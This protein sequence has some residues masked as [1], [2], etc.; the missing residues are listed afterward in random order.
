MRVTTTE[1]GW[2]LEAIGDLEWLFLER[3]PGTASG[4]ELPEEQKRRILP[5]PIVSDDEDGGAAEE[6]EFMEDWNEYVRPELNVAFTEAR[7]QVSDD[8]AT[9]T[10]N[11]SAE[12]MVEVGE[13]PQKNFRLEVD[14]E[15]SENWYSTL[16]QARLLMNEVYDLAESEAELY[17][18]M[19]TEDDD[20]EGEG[21]EGTDD[22][23]DIV[24][25]DSEPD[26]MLWLLLAQYQFY[27]FIQG[28]LL[29]R[30]IKA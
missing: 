19:A 10:R 28:F 18:K 12:A 2:A 6:A 29:E 1:N 23:D 7:Q 15:H 25:E 14:G 22:A 21:E 24:E 5:D 9:V 4:E 8:L 17:A 11:F 20:G 13:E 27:S 26:G 30:V 16:N 3:L